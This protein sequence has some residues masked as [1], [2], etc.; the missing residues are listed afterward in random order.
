MSLCGADI[1]GFLWNVN[2]N[3]LQR[4]YQAAVWM[5][6]F[7]QH[8]N[9]DTNRREP[10]LYD[11]Y[12]QDRIRYAIQLRYFHLPLWYTLFYEH[13]RTGEPVIKPLVYNYPTDENVFENDWSW[14]V[15]DNILARPVAEDNVGSVEIYFPGGSSELW[16]DVENTLLYTGSGSFTKEVSLDSNLY[17]YRGGSIIPRR[18]TVRSASVYTLEDPV[19]LYVF[20]NTSNQATGTLYA[21]D[22]MTFDYKNKKEYIYL[23][24][25][26]SGGSLSSEYIDNDAYWDGPLS[27]GN[28]I[29]YRPPSGVK[30]A[31]L[32]T[33]SRG[34]VDLE[35]TYGPNDFYM[36]IENINLDLHEPF[37]IDFY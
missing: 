9:S 13:Y 31:K 32:Q 4:W 34:I 10:Y 27:F 28:T 1:G 30:G 16:Y 12:I 19:T 20:L 3:L 37:K 8:S 33:K 2:D 23:R 35:V 15:G 14:L 24:F 17:F 26:Y 29:V 5:P 6:F 11:D 7:R 21:D 22:T 36:T 25:T 18:N